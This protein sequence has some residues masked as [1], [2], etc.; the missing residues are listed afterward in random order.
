MILTQAGFTVDV[1]ENGKEAVEKIAVSL[2][3]DYDAVLMD[4]QMPVMDGF[5]ATRKIRQLENKDLANIPIIAMTANAF[6][7]DAEAAIK[8]G[9]Q[10]HVAK[11]IDVNVL[12]STL[13]RILSESHET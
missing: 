8:A 10:A 3:G 6:K 5:T 9:M 4:V 1:A 7:E 12:L 13:A 2:K 11:P